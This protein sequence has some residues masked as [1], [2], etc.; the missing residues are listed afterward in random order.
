MNI[1]A[2]STELLMS[3][4]PDID[5]ASTE[6][7]VQKRANEKIAKKTDLTSL[8]GSST[9]FN[10]LSIY[11]PIYDSDY[12]RILTSAS[13]GTGAKRLDALIKKSDNSLIMLKVY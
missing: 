1:N 2:I 3:I 12:F 9:A 6:L 13:S 11:G 5:L 10:A 7:I 4:S 8:L